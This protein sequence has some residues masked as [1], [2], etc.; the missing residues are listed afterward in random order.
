MN[1]NS[2]RFHFYKKTFFI[3]ETFNTQYVLTLRNIKYYAAYSYRKIVI[4]FQKY[5]F[6]EKE[7]CTEK[8]LIFCA[9]LYCILFSNY[10]S[11]FCNILTLRL[12][13]S[14]V[15]TIKIVYYG[16]IFQNQIL[17]IFYD[18]VSR[19][20]VK[21][22]HPIQSLNFSH[23]QQNTHG[24]SIDILAQRHCD[25]NTKLAWVGWGRGGVGVGKQFNT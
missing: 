21:Y 17:Y 22:F 1:K 7:E 15:Q 9:V 23:V 12:G 2:F 11:T 18:T 6:Q 3:K 19:D 20:T 5:S 16:H 24:F 25:R 14:H 13:V 4:S 10:S 8:I